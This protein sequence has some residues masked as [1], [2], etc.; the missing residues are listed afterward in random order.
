MSKNN[1]WIRS[2][3]YVMMQRLSIFLFGFGSYY[4][5]V[6]YF[7]KAEF[8]VWVL[9]IT[10]TSIVEMSRSA[11]IQ[12]AFVKFFNEPQTDKSALIMSSL[13][14]NLLST[15]FFILVLVLLNP[16]LAKFWNTKE[17]A[18]LIFWY[19]LTSFILIPF[20][21]LNY[22]EQANHNFKGVFW[23]AVVRQGLF[24]VTVVIVFFKVPGLSLS[25]F[26]ALQSVCAL[27][28]L[29]TVCF[30]SAKHIPR[31]LTFNW[32]LTGKLFKFGKYILGTGVTSSIGKSTDQIILGSYNHGTVALYN[33]AIRVMNFIEIPS[34]SI[35]NIV[36]PKIAQKAMTE[37]KAGAHRLYEQ[38]VASIIAIILP[39]I[40]FIFLFARFVLSITAGSNY[41]E[42][43]TIL[44]LLVASAI[45]IPFNIQVGSAFEV[46]GKPQVSFYINLVA[47][48]VNLVMNIALVPIYG[49]L[50]AAW[51]LVGSTLSTFLIS[52]FLLRRELGTSIFSVLREVVNFYSR[53]PRE[54]I[55]FT[56]R[57]K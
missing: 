53:V 43:N 19:C 28:G 39:V 34:L 13:L 50:G 14:L 29:L 38:S 23:S 11:F 42:A 41:V 47:N 31:G 44:Q 20:T 35:S 16:V 49:A 56:T 30:F 5:M 52:Q 17:M 22:I 4:F 12:N 9:F 33:S 32:P 21:Q 15:L 48:L 6:R 54:V 10:V 37:G 3:G 25:F 24:F 1:Y 40:L 2:G 27:A 57:N 51:S 46:I 7:P 55:K 8:G 26:A 36:Y 45:F 18:E